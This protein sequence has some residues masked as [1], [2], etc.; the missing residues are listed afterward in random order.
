MLNSSKRFGRSLAGNVFWLL[1]LLILGAF[2][3]LPLIYTILQA[4]KPL[5]ELML[6]PPRFFV[7]RPSLDN[8]RDLVK[9]TSTS[10]VP[11]GRYVVNTIFVTIVV[12]ALNVIIASMGGFS[13]AKGLFPG[14][15]WI[16]KLVVTALLFTSQVTGIIQYIIMAKMHIV[17]TYLAL[18][19]PNL[20]GSMGLFLMKQFMEQIP[21]SLIEAGKIDGAKLFLIWRSIIMPNVKPAWLTLTMFT[22]QASWGLTASNLI[23]SEDLKTLPTALSQLSSSGVAYAGVGAAAT[24]IVALPPI[25]LFVF[26]QGNIIQTMAH[27]GIKE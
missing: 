9:A 23:Y 27:S 21:D 6:F 3:A 16:F 25:I 13:L 4:F 10:L 8:F 5:E 7:R 24:I 17:D 1:F 20:S 12:T 15:R 26:V 2:M 19:L 18:L 14:Q 11:F 22:F